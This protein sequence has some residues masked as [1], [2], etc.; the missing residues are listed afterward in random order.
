MNHSAIRILCLLLCA[1][2][3]T[4]CGVDAEPDAAKPSKEVTASVHDLPPRDRTPTL[5]SRIIRPEEFIN[6]IL[7]Y[8]E[9]FSTDYS[10][11]EVLEDSQDF[12]MC[13]LNYNGE[14]A[15]DVVLIVHPKE[16]WVMR[17]TVRLLRSD[18][19]NGDQVCL[20]TLPAFT[21]VT[22]TEKGQDFVKE[23]ESRIEAY[24]LESDAILTVEDWDGNYISVWLM[25][26][27]DINRYEVEVFKRS[28]FIQE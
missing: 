4:G 27:G 23:M 11:G 22:E 25:E 15:F 28:D 8:A 13:N 26:E 18:V 20:Y 17:A 9:T 5:S 16:G 1:L 7:D 6:A 2:L 10:M 12:Y 21:G 24:G 19:P 14:P 3:L